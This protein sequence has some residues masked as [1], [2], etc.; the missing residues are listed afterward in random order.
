MQKLING[1]PI[2]VNEEGY[3]TNLTQWNEGVAETIATEEGVGPLTTRHWDVLRFLQD[4]QRKEVAL[5]IRR[6]GQSGVV[7]IKEF[8]DLFPGGPLKK[9]SKIAGIPKPASCI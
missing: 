7:S 6:I 9:A 1:Q 3:L 8:Y 4:Q 5:T 2:D